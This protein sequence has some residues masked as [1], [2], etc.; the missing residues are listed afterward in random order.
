M[1]TTQEGQAIPRT[2]G[3]V[4][5]A[6]VLCVTSSVVLSQQ[7]PVRFVCHNDVDGVWH[8]HQ[9]GPV[10]PKDRL[11]VP[12]EVMLGIDATLNTVSD[13]GLGWYAERDGLGSPWRKRSK[14][15]DEIY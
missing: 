7:A 1:N 13:L 9:G 2:P 8:L 10:D 3:T 6:G 14:P 4:A 11:T 15:P 5:V 12:L